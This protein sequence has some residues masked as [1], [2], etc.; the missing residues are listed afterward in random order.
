MKFFLLSSSLL[1]LAGVA[2]CASAVKLENVAGTWSCPRVDGVCADIATLDAELV[3]APNVRG[4]GGGSETIAADA[5]RIA[6][7]A[8][9]SAMPARTADE[10]ARIVFA[11]SIDTAGHFHGARAVYAVMKPGEWIEGPV[12]ETPEQSTSLVDGPTAPTSLIETDET[13]S[14]SLPA[15]IGETTTRVIRRTVSP[16]SYN[17]ADLDQSHDE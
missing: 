12:E 15:G 6:I 5:A 16:A 11:P 7:S 8:A 4:I 13:A 17:T 10:I 3:G 2:G 9:S 1:A 14:A